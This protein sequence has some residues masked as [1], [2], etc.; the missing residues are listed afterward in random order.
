[1]LA[2]KCGVTHDHSPTATP[3]HNCFA[4][5]ATQT[6]LNKAKCLL[7][8]SNLPKQYWAEAVNTAT[9]LS[10]L[11]PTPSQDNLSPFSLWTIVITRHALF[12]ENHFPSINSNPNSDS[13]SDR[14]IDLCEERDECINNEEV[15]TD[16]GSSEVAE[17]AECLQEQGE[18]FAQDA[19]PNDRPLR[20][21]VVG[22]RHPTIISGDIS[23]SNILPYSRQPK[24][25]VTVKDAN[26]ISYRSALS[27]SNC[28]DWKKAISKELNSMENLKVWSVV[29]LKPSM[30]L[31]GTTLVFRTKRDVM[32]RITKYKA[33]L[34]TQGFSQ[35]L[36]VDYSK[37]FA[38]TG[39]LSSLRT[40]IAFSAMNGL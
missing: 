40:L 13:H 37:T 17:G 28:E 6:I 29:D 11:M 8:G 3:Q 30:K 35:T 24:T 5:R 9:F 39:R 16:Q 31:V 12:A 1:M 20:L 23:Q 19:T 7:I 36:G 14:W 38:P 27:D 34:C 25:F 4:E 18:E 26:P 2:S 22:P 21:R 15:L 32:N 33:Q 10:N